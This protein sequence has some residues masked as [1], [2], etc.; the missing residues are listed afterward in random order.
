MEIEEIRNWK[1]LCAEE[2]LSARTG[3]RVISKLCF[4]RRWKL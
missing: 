3:F 1:F 4:D 2:V